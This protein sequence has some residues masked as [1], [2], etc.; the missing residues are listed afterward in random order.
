MAVAWGMTRPCPSR[1]GRSRL[2]EEERGVAEGAGLLWCI[3]VS[4]LRIKGV[5]R[6]WVRGFPRTVQC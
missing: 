5:L 6:V 2:E 4:L 1:C 3:A